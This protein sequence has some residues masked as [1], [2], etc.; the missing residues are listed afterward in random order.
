MYFTP[1]C[2]TSS[3]SF[4]STCNGLAS[5]W[6]R[7]E[8]GSSRPER[9]GS[10]RPTSTRSPERR[11]FLPH[12]DRLL[13]FSTE[14][15]LVRYVRTLGAGLLD[16]RLRSLW[17][18]ASYAARGNRC[19]AYPCYRTFPQRQNEVFIPQPGLA[20]GYWGIEI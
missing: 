13:L 18:S 20:R 9:V 17:H 5:R 12:C 19:A 16:C 3:A 8:Y 14:S 1:F 11:Q 4:S 15:L 2:A 7:I 6:V 10:P